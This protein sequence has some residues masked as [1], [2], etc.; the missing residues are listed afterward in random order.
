MDVEEAAQRIHRERFW[1]LTEKQIA[2][3]WQLIKDTSEG[4]FYREAA[5]AV[6]ED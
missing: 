4:K 5:R 1:G 6:L 2:E 3:R